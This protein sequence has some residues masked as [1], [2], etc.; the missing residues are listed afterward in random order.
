VRI[1][2]VLAVLLLA[3]CQKRRVL[4]VEGSAFRLVNGMLLPPP[5]AGGS[6]V[7]AFDLPRVKQGCGTGRVQMK[8]PAIDADFGDLL[9]GPMELARRG[10]VDASV[11][12]QMRRVLRESVP[13]R[14]NSGLYATYGYRP[15]VSVV[16]LR[17]G[18]RLKM[19]RALFDKPVEQRS[20]SID[21]Y[22]GLKT[23]I[24]DCEEDG[25]GFVSIGKL[26]GARK[27]YRFLMLTHYVKAGVSRS[28]VLLGAD[29]LSEVEE[30]ER[31]LKANPG[32]AC[33]K[34]RTGRRSVCVAFDG[35]V[36]VS[37]EVLVTVNGEKKALAWGTT[38]KMVAGGAKEITLRRLWMEKL[39]SIEIEADLDAV[40]AT[41]LVGGDVVEYR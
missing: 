33:L 24:Y 11:A 29:R 12:L 38:V 35:E 6:G 5:V 25:R 39:R 13:M 2:L 8:V 34:V 3:G 26:A 7:V 21:G 20:S 22:T 15:G 9:E 1:L 16:E 36:T 10:C 37:P 40:G 30:M 27:V 18:V 41:V 4:V 23:E 32:E 17:A 28:A 31:R 14:P 19:V